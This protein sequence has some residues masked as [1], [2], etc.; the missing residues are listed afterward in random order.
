MAGRVGG[1]DGFYANRE[2]VQDAAV[3]IRRQREADVACVDAA[4][5]AAAGWFF[6][7]GDV[8]APA[9]KFQSDEAVRLVGGDGRLEIAAFFSV[10]R[11]RARK[12]SLARGDGG[13]KLLYWRI[14]TKSGRSMCCGQLSSICH[15]R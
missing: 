3:V 14:V 2:G 12:S 8:E 9:G 1:D 10:P 4:A 13:V 11:I 5:Q 15:D 6:L 7:A